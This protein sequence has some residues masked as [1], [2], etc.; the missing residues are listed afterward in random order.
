M[1]SVIP[2]E[3]EG[4]VHLPKDTLSIAFENTLFSLIP[5]QNATKDDF[6]GKGHLAGNLRIL[7]LAI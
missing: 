6:S 2:K 3:K 7:N 1:S 5:N 4:T